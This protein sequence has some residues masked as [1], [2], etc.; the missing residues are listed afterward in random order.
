MSSRKVEQRKCVQFKK[1]YFRRV[2]NAIKRFRQ[3]SCLFGLRFAYEGNY[4][5]ILRTWSIRSKV[6]S[7]S[8]LF[9]FNTR[10][11]ETFYCD[12]FISLRTRFTMQTFVNFRHLI[13]TR[14]NVLSLYT[15][16]RKISAGLPNV[17]CPSSGHILSRLRIFPVNVA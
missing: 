1:N 16:A 3:S 8:R 2:N 6:V 15:R 17:F 11:K 4:Q 14:S 9:S 7:Y 12:T 13:P 10:R 5:R